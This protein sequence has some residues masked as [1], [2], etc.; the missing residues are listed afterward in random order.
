[1]NNKEEEKE[2]EFGDEIL[3]TE[4]FKENSAYEPTHGD[5]YIGEDLQKAIKNKLG[6]TPQ[7]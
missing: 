6:N 4:C 1:M 2:P 3:N 7:R 5:R